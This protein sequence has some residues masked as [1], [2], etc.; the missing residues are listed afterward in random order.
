MCWYIRVLSP[1]IWGLESQRIAWKSNL[2]SVRSPHVPNNQK[3]RDFTNVPN[4]RRFSW[5]ERPSLVIVDLQLF[6]GLPSLLPNARVAATPGKKA[7]VAAHH[8]DETSRYALRS[9]ILQHQTRRPCNHL[10]IGGNTT[11]VLGKYDSYPSKNR[12]ALSAPRRVALRLRRTWHRRQSSLDFQDVSVSLD[13]CNTGGNLIMHW[14]YP[15]PACITENFKTKFPFSWGECTPMTGAGRY[16][17]YG[18]IRCKKT[19]KES[20]CTA[21]VAPNRDASSWH[22]SKV[23]LQCRLE[24]RHWMSLVSMSIS[25]QAMSEFKDLGRLLSVQSFSSQ[26]LSCLFQECRENQR[27]HLIHWMLWQIR[28][29]HWAG[30]LE[31]RVNEEMPNP[32]YENP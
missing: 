8:N 15:S 27:I 28:G 24:K 31:T 17:C 18:S 4:I 10:C 5:A 21:V 6:F 1:R 13:G 7:A 20:A 12:Q 2:K 14:S 26:L 30:N 11:Q 9:N 22:W 29:F 16:T 23:G 19:S 3:H 32:I 25:H